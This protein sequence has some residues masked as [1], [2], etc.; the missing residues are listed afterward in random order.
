MQTFTMH[1]LL[2]KGEFT[3]MHTLTHIIIKGRAER[4]EMN[5]L[6]GMLTTKE[7]GLPAM[8]VKAEVT[9]EFAASTTEIGGRGGGR[10]LAEVPTD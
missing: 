3:P 8:V 10:W 1:A 2:L 5:S 4:R 6:M 9:G 7:R